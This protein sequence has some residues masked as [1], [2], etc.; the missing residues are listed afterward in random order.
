MGITAGPLNTLHRHDPQSGVGLW[1]LQLDSPAVAVH[2]A[3]GTSLQL[4]G[5][6]NTADDTSSVVVGTLHGSMYALPVAADWLQSGL[7]VASTA[8]QALDYQPASGNTVT[9]SGTQSHVMKSPQQPV[10]SGPQDSAGPES[11]QH[12]QHEFQLLI[13]DNK[14]AEANGA[15]KPATGPDCKGRKRAIERLKRQGQTPGPGASTAL[16]QLPEKA[17][18]A[19]PISLHSV[20]INAAPQSFLPNLTDAICGGDADQQPSQAA[21]WNGGN[22]LASIPTCASCAHP[23][24]TPSSACHSCWP[25]SHVSCHFSLHTRHMI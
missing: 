21:Q 16:M 22:K 4:H 7:P 1:T 5:S 6:G 12:A 8:P 15:I 19:S 10:R 24:Y 18:W 23:V 17:E 11:A 25:M 3:D 2:L 20:V 9:G 13:H 14:A